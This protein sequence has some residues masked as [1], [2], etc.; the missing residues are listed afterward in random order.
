MMPDGSLNQ[1]EE[2]KTAEN[3]KF[4]GKRKIFS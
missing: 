3:G 2:T 4:M 1:Q